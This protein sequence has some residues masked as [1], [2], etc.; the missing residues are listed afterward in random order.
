[1]R[2]RLISLLGIVGL[3]LGLLVAPVGATTVIDF[4]TGNAGYGGIVS[5]FSDGNL[6]GADIPVGTV[7][8]VGA[9]QNNSTYGVSGP[10]NS[11]YGGFVGS[12]NFSTGGLAGTN[13]IGI[14]G[15][16][17][18]LDLTTTELLLT[19]T[20]SSYSSPNASYGLVAA[21][22]LDSKA[23]DLLNAIGLDPA[24]QFEYFAFSISTGFLNLP[25]AGQGP[26]TSSA[27]STDIRNTE[28]VPEPSSLVLV[29]TGIVALGALRRYRRVASA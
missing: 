2:L 9:P 3:A 4:S 16:I 11:S 17:V 5:L 20:I 7:T 18:G 1:M 8:I 29:A 14:V 22:G 25:T 12:L 21:V 10:A 15:S 24:T 6:S 28:R 19:G 23:A 27:I 26:S 13:V